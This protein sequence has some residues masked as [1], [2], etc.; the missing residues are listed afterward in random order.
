MT[1]EQIYQLVNA[2]CQQLWG[3]Q[4]IT[5]NDLSGLISL[6]NK[7]FATNTDR[8]GF[9]NTLAD[10]IT[11]TNFRTLDN[12]V[13]FPS[14]LRNEI[15]WGAIVQKVNVNCLP[16]QQ[17]DWTEIG[18]VGYTPN[19]FKIDKPQ[20][21][22]VLFGEPRL[23]FQF[24]MTVPDTLYKSAFTSPSAMGAFIT[25]MMD[26]MDKSLIEAIN[27]MN[28]D[29]L[30]NLIAEKFKANHNIVHVVT[31]FNLDTGASETSATCRFN[32]DFLRY[33]AQKLDD[34]IKY[35]SVSSTL[36]NEGINNNPQLRA[37]QRDNMHCIISAE[38]ASSARFQLYSDTYNY[39]FTELPLYD[40]FVSL[41]GSGTT[42][43]NF[44][45]DTTIDVIPSS[46]AGAGTPT[47]VQE[48]Y[49]GAILCDREALG[50]T[51]RDMYTA[52]DRNNRDRYTN[53]TSG[54]GL[55][56]F[57]DLSENCVIFQLD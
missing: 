32:K 30:C 10:R 39:Q 17:S 52:T 2:T 35:M 29:C 31:Q 57:N 43:H 56:Y 37:T 11:K 25:A 34:Y 8:D 53:Y 36:Y 3:T 47:A 9:I 54:C 42:A 12:R 55:A 22:Q 21:T 45:S 15:E 7:V 18:N 46:E 40:E 4:A 27:G 33:F 38:L 48:D 16:A 44:Q 13:E 23:V 6:G 26:A 19:Q 1:Y 20:I 5:T 28:H 50:T 49:I 41:Q 14:F 24:C 51:W